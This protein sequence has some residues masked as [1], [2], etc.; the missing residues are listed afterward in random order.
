[1]QINI[2]RKNAGLSDSLRTYV[3]SKLAELEN[4]YDKIIDARVM[5]HENG[6]DNV[7]EINLHSVGR[8]FFAKDQ[9]SNLRAAFDSCIDKLDRQLEKKK[10]K[11]RRKSLTQEE[12][13]LAGKMIVE[14]EPEEELV[15]EIEQPLLTFDAEEDEFEEPEERTGT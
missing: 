5:M 13:I 10:D 15:G 12:S 9:S 14:S 6:R 3:E 11:L 1:M 7:V 8:T 2:T 4:R